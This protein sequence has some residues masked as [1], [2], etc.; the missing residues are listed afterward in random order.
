MLKF[1]VPL[2]S[3]SIVP[4]LPTGYV[5]LYNS[6]TGNFTGVYVKK[7]TI[8]DRIKEFYRKYLRRRNEL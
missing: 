7:K 6:G 8:L 3:G 1:K 2:H 4:H 5:P